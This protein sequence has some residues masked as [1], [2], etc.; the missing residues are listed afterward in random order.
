MRAIKDVFK[1]PE[2]GWKQTIINTTLIA[3]VFLGGV[4]L[5]SG[6]IN[7]GPDAIFRKSV[8]N[9]E[10]GALQYSGVEEIYESLQEGY[11]GQLDLNKLEDGLKAGLVEAAGDEYTEYLNAEE[12]QDFNEQLS[13]SFEGIGAELGKEEQ[14]IVIIA[15]IEGFPAEKAGLKAR[16]IISEID[17]QSAYDISVS[18]AVKK[19]RG[20]KGTK[21]KLQVVR[22]GQPLEFEITRAA[23]NLPSVKTEITSDNVGIIEISRFGSDTVEL[24]R[25]AANE[26]KD[27]NVKGVVLDVRGNPGGLLD[28]AVGVSEIWLDK[29]DLILQEKRGEQVVKTFNAKGSS[30][31]GNVPTVVLV[32]EGSASASE[33]VAGALRDNGAAVIIGQTTY[34]KGSVQEVRELDDGGVLK[35]TVA[36]WYTP[37][38]KNID[39]DGIEPDQEIELTAEDV[40]ADRDPQ[41]DAALQKLHQ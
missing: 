36:R 22:E 11:D 18:D 37:A 12:A 27:K 1:T 40:K 3:A 19:I 20:E 34:G 39:K 2:K 23:I 10:L 35:V 8:Q 28:A 5:G 15:P 38:G 26:F 31:L 13:G 33:I 25:K 16:D 6:R 14:S 32:D 4:V 24:T 21:V 7:L 9:S 17:G 41:K 29:G 30:I